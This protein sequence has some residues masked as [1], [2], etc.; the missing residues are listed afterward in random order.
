MPSM[1]LIDYFD[2]CYEFIDNAVSK[3]SNV[4]IHCRAGRN[5][6]FKSGS[7]KR[8]SSSSSLSSGMSRSATIA[9]AYM[10]KKYRLSYENAMIRLKQ[11]RSFVFP[12]A[13][14]KRQLLLYEN[15]ISQSATTNPIEKQFAKIEYK[16]KFCRQILF[17]DID[18]IGHISGKGRFDAHSKSSSYKAK[19]NAESNEKI[20]CQQ[21][22]FTDQPIW[23]TDIFNKEI[24]DGDILCP[25]LKCRAKLGRYSLI[26]EKCSCAKWVNPAFHF[27]RTKIDEC[28]VNSNVDLL[29]LRK[30]FSKKSDE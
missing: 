24:N 26:G 9:C 25:N 16:C 10:M 22:W 18:L 19:Q 6:F 13:G 11:K 8:N 29:L 2:D 20:L 4:L 27:H 12:N 23:L 3:Q 14:F 7:F 15:Q 28:P 1:E 17:N 21:E 5:F 30:D